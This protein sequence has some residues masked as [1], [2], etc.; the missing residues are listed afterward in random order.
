MSM[1]FLQEWW[2]RFFTNAMARWL[3]HIICVLFSFSNPMSL[4]SCFSHIATFAYWLMAMYST[5]E[6]ENAMEDC[7]FKFHEI[8]PFPII[9]TWPIVD[10][11]SLYLQLNLHYKSL[12]MQCSCFQVPIWLA[13]Y[14]GNTA[15]FSW[16]PLN[17][18][19]YFL[20]YVGSLHSLKMQGQ[21]LCSD[22][23]RLHC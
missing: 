1:C 11:L 9:N 14:L 16:P 22:N 21:A 12:L 5:L 2:V 13:M 4:I 20:P 3:L 18:L 17:A 23:K 19:G 10:F 8:V 7:F 6:V 15:W